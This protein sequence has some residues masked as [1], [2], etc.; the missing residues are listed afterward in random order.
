MKASSASAK[1][2]R[3]G[4]SA[5]SFYRSDRRAPVR[6]RPPKKARHA[7]PYTR[8]TVLLLLVAAAAF[9]GFKSG[10]SGGTPEVTVQNTASNTKPAA[11]LQAPT[12]KPVASAATV[13]TGACA[14]NSLSQLI[15]VS[16]SQRHL[17]A[18]DGSQSAYDS[19]VVTGIDYLAADTTPTG[20][21]HIYSKQ[22]NVTLRGSDSTGSWDD[23][24]DYWMPFLN[25]Q[26]G[27]YGLHDATWRANSDF[28]N[29]SPDSADAS[30]G[31]V[32]LPLAT[33][34][35][36]YDWASVGTTVTIES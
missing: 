5:Y 26:Y 18:C 3:P 22:T 35:W 23:P 2:V 17:W 30:H 6:G 19:P 1:T 11:T 36:L 9:I 8:F 31:C 16:I 7:R 24:V 32:E 15:V 4:L 21:F 28:G 12:S 10:T 25:N 13:S 14:S 33:A 27:T 29:I 20:T 34:K